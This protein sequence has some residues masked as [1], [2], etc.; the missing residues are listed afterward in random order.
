[1]VRKYGSLSRNVD[2]P[3]CMQEESDSVLQGTPRRREKETRKT[4]EEERR[5][6]CLVYDRTLPKLRQVLR[7]CVKLHSEARLRPAE[8]KKLFL[9][10]QKPV[11]SVDILIL[12]LQFATFVIFALFRCTFRWA[13]LSLHCT[14]CM[15]VW[16]NGT[17]LGLNLEYDIAGDETGEDGTW[18]N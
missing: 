10:W 18:M 2:T 8:D 4:G 1:M 13:T 6:L 14:S 3:S 12:S 15:C 11:N 7:L 9:L 17:S 5:R 16:D